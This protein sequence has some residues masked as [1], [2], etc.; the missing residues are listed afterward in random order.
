MF[1]M[2]RCHKASR[3]LG[4]FHATVKVVTVR[5][6]SPDLADLALRVA[7]ADVV[8]GVAAYSAEVAR[9]ASRPSGDRELFRPHCH[10]DFPTA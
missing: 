7:P 1:M 6:V 9:W 3:S 2:P 10:Y 5:M 4:G 8:L